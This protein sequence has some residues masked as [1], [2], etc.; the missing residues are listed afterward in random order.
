MPQD[1]EPATFRWRRFGPQAVEFYPA[2]NQDPQHVS[3]ALRHA[4]NQ[5]RATPP[6][7]LLET[8]SGYQTLLCEFQTRQIDAGV[9]EHILSLLTAPQDPATG[10]LV[11]IPV[12]YTGP[13]I[14]RVANHT[15]LTPKEI[16][17]RHSEREYIVVILGFSPGFPYLAELD[18]ALATPRLPSPR[19]RVPAGSVGI[20]GSQTGVYTVPSPGGWNL[21]GHTTTELFDP[22]GSDET[23]FLLRP[24]DRIRFVPL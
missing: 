23:A 13:D 8:T 14:D 3:A 15:G 18:P 24:G 6:S 7:G 5:L 21:I 16:I 9:T 17:Q 19:P 2:P 11:E 1:A 10:R 12:H 22:E 4:T 20:G